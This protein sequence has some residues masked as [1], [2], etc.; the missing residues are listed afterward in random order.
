MIT[1]LTSA[2]FSEFMVSKASAASVK[3]ELKE[4]GQSTMKK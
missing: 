1:F 2:F 4:R 3:G